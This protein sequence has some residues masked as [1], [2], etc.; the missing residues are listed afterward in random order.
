VSSWL[1]Q[2]FIE[3]ASGS[4]REIC[5]SCVSLTWTSIS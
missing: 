2:V 3:R 5:L 4:L 1:K